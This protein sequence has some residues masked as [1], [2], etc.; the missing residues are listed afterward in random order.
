MTHELRC[1]NGILFGILEGN[2][3]EVKCRSRRCGA[4]PGV[5]VLHRFSIETGAMLDTKK[6]KDPITKEVQDG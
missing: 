2:T 3:L 4:L 5:V 1:D 6:Y